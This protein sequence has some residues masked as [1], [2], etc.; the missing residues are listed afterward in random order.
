MPQLFRHDIQ[1][2]L[3]KCV[4]PIAVFLLFFCTCHFL[5][6]SYLRGTVFLAVR[7]SVEFFHNT[8][9]RRHH[10]RRQMLFQMPP[11]YLSDFFGRT[12]AF[13]KQHYGILLV[14]PRYGGTDLFQIFSLIFY[15]FQFHTV[16]VY[17]HHVVIA[18]AEPY[19]TVHALYDIP[20]A[21]RS[22]PVCQHHSPRLRYVLI[23]IYHRRFK[24]IQHTRRTVIHFSHILVQNNI[25][26][27]VYRRADRVHFAP[28]LS[29]AQ[30]RCDVSRCF[31]HAVN[32]PN[33]CLIPRN[34]TV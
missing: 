14:Q 28:V 1:Y 16:A 21:E 11:Q 27:T 20:C 23:F 33:L 5:I 10:V 17:L 26:D 30:M 22:A 3:F 18:P 2:A 6:F 13:R 12:A 25:L 9:D 15:L 4:Q 24:Q 7:Q 32:V 19:L 34:K 29:P 8:Y 31:S